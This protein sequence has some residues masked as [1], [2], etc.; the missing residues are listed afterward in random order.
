M[1]SV[2][3][4]KFTD[5]LKFRDGSCEGT[6]GTGGIIVLNAEYTAKLI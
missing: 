3:A 1:F 6:H 2:L 4:F 5:F